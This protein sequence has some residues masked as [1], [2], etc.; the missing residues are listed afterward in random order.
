VTA[1]LIPEVLTQKYFV[2]RLIILNE[3]IIPTNLGYLDAL[4]STSKKLT[5]LV[6]GEN[7]LPSVQSMSKIL[8]KF[9]PSLVYL[10]VT[11]QK[12]DTTEF[13]ALLSTLLSYNSRLNQLE[14]ISPEMRQTNQIFLEHATNLTSYSYA[15]MMPCEAYLQ[16]LLQFVASHH[17]LKSLTLKF[18]GYEEE[19][20]FISFYVKLV[21]AIQSNMSIIQLDLVIALRVQNVRESAILFSKITN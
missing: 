18:R 20:V 7:L 10:S 5:G 9:K 12:F 14:V 16:P 3:Q 19:S 4:F 15:G 21:A 2:E 13:G 11:Y 8:V 6:F 17:N 1:N